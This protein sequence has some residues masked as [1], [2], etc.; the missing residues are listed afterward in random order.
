[1]NT[2]ISLMAASK[3]AGKSTTTIRRWV[4]DKHINADKNKKGHWRFDPES[5][6]TYLATSN[7]PLPRHGASVADTPNISVTTG[8]SAELIK[9]LHDTIQNERDNNAYLKQIISDLKEKESTLNSEMMKIVNQMAAHISKDTTNKPM[10]LSSKFEKI[11]AV[12]RN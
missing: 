8:G 12:I 5:I 2:T 9:S 3:M 1:M 11:M 10:D 4:S 6:R 7:I